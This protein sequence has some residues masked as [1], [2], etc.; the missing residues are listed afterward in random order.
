MKEREQED[1]NAGE[2]AGPSYKGT[3]TIVW[4]ALWK[5]N[6]KQKLKV[7]IWKCLHDALPVRELIFSRT[8]KGNPMCG[9]YGESVE[10]LEHMLL[11]CT[12]AK[13][14]WEMAPDQWDGLVHLTDNFQKWWSAV[15][16]AQMIRGNDEHINLIVNIL[17]QIWKGRNDREFNHKDKEPHGIIEKASMEWMEFEEANRG[18]NERRIM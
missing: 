17:W 7:F 11:Q 18:R 12:K 9:G 3:S 4:E 10:T 5:Q 1:G 14:I 15:I 6:V 13:E 16:K 8:N 2:E